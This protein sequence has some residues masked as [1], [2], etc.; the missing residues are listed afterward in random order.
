MDKQGVRRDIAGSP[1]GAAVHSSI[2]QCE[3]ALL[4]E[5]FPKLR[6]AIVPSSVPLAEGTTIYLNAGNYSLYITAFKD[7]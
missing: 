6:R 7:M 1:N 4:V 3:A 2:L 5:Y